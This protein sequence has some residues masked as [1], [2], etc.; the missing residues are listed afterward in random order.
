MAAVNSWR[1]FVRPI[2][3]M[4]VA[5]IWYRWVDRRNKL[6]MIDSFR[7]A[8]YV[9]TAYYTYRYSFHKSR[10]SVIEK[11]AAFLG[12]LPK[13]FMEQKPSG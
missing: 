1:W 12:K 7:H 13:I 11:S 2:D 8:T 6:T 5:L 3:I 9:K 10:F 4:H